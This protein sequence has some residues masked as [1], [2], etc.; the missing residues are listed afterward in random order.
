M[1]IFLNAS[2]L[3]FLFPDHLLRYP[4]G[5]TWARLTLSRTC[6]SVRLVRA[7]GHS[8]A[9]L[10]GQDGFGGRDQHCGCREAQGVLRHGQGGRVELG[11]DEAEG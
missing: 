5:C 9:Q 2:N 8:D 1:D 4:A 3:V 10:V 7:V 6:R 11:G